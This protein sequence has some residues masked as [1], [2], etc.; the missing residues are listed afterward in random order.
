M[1]PIRFITVAVSTAIVISSCKPSSR[2]S[3]FQGPTPSN[4]LSDV[5]LK[6]GVSLSGTSKLLAFGKDNP[7]SDTDFWLFQIDKT[8]QL[9]LPEK[10]S[11]M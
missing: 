3:G 10:P 1:K 5:K 8:N 9:Q 4:I 6:T 11:L 7:R 2:Q